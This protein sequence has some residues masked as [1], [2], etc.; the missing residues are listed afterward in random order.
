M[1]TGALRLLRFLYVHAHLIRSAYTGECCSVPGPPISIR[2]LPREEDYTREKIVGGVTAGEM[3]KIAALFQAKE[4]YE[5]SL[6]QVRA[7]LC[8]P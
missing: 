6:A 2:T 5:H 7:Q 3:V 8:F 1:R 4:F